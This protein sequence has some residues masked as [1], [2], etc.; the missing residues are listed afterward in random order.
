MLT[1]NV[2]QCSVSCPEVIIGPYESGYGNVEA[3][4]EALSGSFVGI[5]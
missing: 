2:V 5:T 3:G 4:V 1:Q